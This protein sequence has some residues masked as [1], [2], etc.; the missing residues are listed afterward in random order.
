MDKPPRPDG[1]PSRRPRRIKHERSAG[2]LVLKRRDG[3]FEGLIIGRASPR[4]WSLPKGHVEPSESIESAAVREVHEETSIEADIIEKLS[5]IRYWFYSDKIKHSKVVHFFLMRYVRG[6]PSP[7]EGEVDEV[8]WVPLDELLSVLTHL[9][10][11]RL[12]TMA[13]NI[14]SERGAEGLGFTS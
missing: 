12:A 14:V 8:A 6:M 10:E 1:R 5:D 11:R 13:Q 7:Q 3:G 4:I 2:G 9:N